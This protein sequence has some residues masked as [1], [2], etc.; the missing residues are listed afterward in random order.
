LIETADVYG[1]MA[2]DLTPFDTSDYPP[3][4][5]CWSAANKKVVLK[6]KDEANGVPVRAF[7]GLRAKMYCMLTA[8]NVAEPTAKGIVRSEIARLSWAQY[9]VALFGTTAEEK[10]QSVSFCAI[11]ATNHKVSTLRMTKTGLCAY[12]DKRYVL[13]DNVRTLAHGHWRIEAL[14]AEAAEAEAAE[15]A[16]AAAAAIATVVDSDETM[17]ADVQ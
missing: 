11:R 13:N 7:A 3:D 4:H 1:D 14:R 9:E 17:G 15:V 10:R 8:G 6:M 12:D 16:V 5:K 2:A